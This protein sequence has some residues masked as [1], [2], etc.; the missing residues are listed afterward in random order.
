MCG[1]DESGASEAAREAAWLSVLTVV[2]LNETTRPPDSTN[3]LA[4]RQPL[5][6]PTK[7]CV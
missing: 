7:L 3:A 4:I 1:S 5:T 2:I 6:A